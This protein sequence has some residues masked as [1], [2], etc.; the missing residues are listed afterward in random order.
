MSRRQIMIWLIALSLLVASAAGVLAHITP[1]VVL[2][3]D[4]DAVVE[5][6]AGAKRF[7]VRE[8]RLTVEERDRIQKE[9]GWK[10]DND[11]YRFYLGRDRQGRLVG[12]VIFLTEFTIHGP[13]RVAVDIGP[14][15][16]VK[17]AKIV[18]LTEET[19][20]WLKPL[21]DQ[22]FTQEY[23]GRDSRASFTP[24]GRF[25][26][27]NLQNMPYFYAQIVASLIQRGTILSEVTFFEKNE[28]T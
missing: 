16:R 19:Y 20:Y 9:W 11:F 26:E 28:G 7:F 22:N 4:R 12:A 24:S 2:L 5:M 27:A 1:P 18:E 25:A 8:V 23:V 17:D 21:V 6:L 3:S 14:D 13:V 15:G 10:P